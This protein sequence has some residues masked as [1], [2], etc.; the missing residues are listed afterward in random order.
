MSCSAIG[1][2]CKLAVQDGATRTFSSSSERYIF[3]KEDIKPTHLWGDNQ[4]GI[5]EIGPT[6]SAKRR[7][8]TVYSGSIILEGSR[9]NMQTWLPRALWSPTSP[10]ITSG[11][12]YT[13]YEFDILI[14][15]ENDVFRYN[16]C[17]VDTMTI[18]SDVDKQL[19]YIALGVVAQ[20]ETRATAWPSPEPAVPTTAPNYPYTHFESA[21]T[22][23]SIDIPMDRVS[24][25]I[26]NRLVPIIRRSL[27]ALKF[28]SQ[29]REI[30]LSGIST[31]DDSAF[32]ELDAMLDDTADAT[33]AYDHADIGTVTMNFQNFQNIQ[34][35]TPHIPGQTAIPVP[36]QLRANKDNIST[37]ELSITFAS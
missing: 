25:Q 2:F 30:T 35:T 3:I 8:A 5:G 29:G 4:W 31:F 6:V 33:F 13:D 11:L 19:C 10:T 9:Q 14:D 17:L 24:M 7:K 28:R 16:N 20:T 18:F 15:R 37:S 1:E 21:L 32:P 34:H 36:F 22:I 27:T 26:S 23:N 12:D